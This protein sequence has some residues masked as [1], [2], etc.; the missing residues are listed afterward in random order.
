MSDQ[1]ITLL[2]R[3]VHILGGVFWVGSVLFM[4]GFIFPTVRASGPEGGRFVQQLMVQRR[5][6]VYLMTAM[7]LTLLSGF[8]LYGRLTAATQGAWAGTPQGM[9]YGLGGLAAVLAVIAGLTI[10]GPAGRRL[11]T[12]GQEIAKSGAPSPEQQAEMA[13]LQG[14]AILGGRITA[15][16]LIVSVSAM[17]VARY[18]S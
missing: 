4:A 7:A 3:L 16:L 13:R 8:T 15:A 9:V 1:T 5:L 6:P 10:S 12:M 14:R 2:L 11:G 17:A 18:V